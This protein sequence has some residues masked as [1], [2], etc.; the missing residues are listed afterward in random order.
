MHK[1]TYLGWYKQRMPRLVRPDSYSLMS[2]SMEE[3]WALLKTHHPS[4]G[5]PVFEER[6]WTPNPYGLPFLIEGIGR[7]YGVPKENVLLTQGATSAIYLIAQT[8]IHPGDHVLVERPGYEPLMHAPAMCGAV[9]DELHRPDGRCP[10]AAAI[11]SVI[12][13]DTRLIMLTNLHNPTGTLC[14]MSQL[15]TLVDA[16]KAVSPDIRIVLDEIYLDFVPGRGAPASTLDPCILSVSSLTKVYGFSTLRCGWIFAEPEDIDRL[17]KNQVVISGIG[18]RYLETLASL[19]IDHLNEYRDQAFLRLSVNRPIL[20]RHLD[21]MVAVGRLTGPIPDHGC[22]AFL[23]VPGVPDTIA[24]TDYLESRFQLFTVPGCFFGA[25]HYIRIGI[26]EI[27]AVRL[28]EALCR[29]TKGL[30]SF[31]TPD[32]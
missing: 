21:P 26:G 24:L 4:P 30:D 17:R 20:H 2:S 11:R 25:P 10:D 19:V 31:Q 7:H 15:K 12:R 3:A 1:E 23:R 13:P 32:R 18:S 9:I 14:E 16:A 29:F 6:Y 5:H 28:D 27:N 22:V 8:F